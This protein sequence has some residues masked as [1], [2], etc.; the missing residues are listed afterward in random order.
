MIENN[1]KNHQIDRIQ[2]NKNDAI[3]NILFKSL[4]EVPDYAHENMAFITSGSQT[5]R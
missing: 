4:E 3:R 5:H 1:N 2:R